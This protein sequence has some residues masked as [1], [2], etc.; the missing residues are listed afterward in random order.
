MLRA[1]L[2]AWPLAFRP[3]FFHFVLL[4]RLSDYVAVSTFFAVLPLFS[5]PRHDSCFAFRPGSARNREARRLA[6]AH[7]RSRELAMRTVLS[8]VVLAIHS[9]LG[10]QV[11]DSEAVAA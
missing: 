9:V 6:V 11:Q 3:S 2:L 4:Q 1:C 7:R 5:L 8:R 10:E